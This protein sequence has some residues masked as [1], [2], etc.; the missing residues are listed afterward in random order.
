MPTPHLVS[1]PLECG[2]VRLRDWQLSDLDAY[3]HWMHPK[4]DWHKLD[5]PY[6]PKPAPDEIPRFVISK[7]TEIERDTWPM[8][9][10]QL[11]IADR[12]SDA[13][14]GMVSWYWIGE[15]TNWLAQG[16]VIY[17]PTYW[18]R[19]IGTVAFGLWGQYL[20]DAMPHIVRL[21]LRTWS[22][23]LGMQ[24]LARRL[25]YAEEARFRMARIV[26]GDYYDGLGFGI[27]RGEWFALYPHSFAAHYN[28][29]RNG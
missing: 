26:D 18:R 23:N 20:F 4:H 16:I 15:E 2:P 10:E 3:A 27:L 1:L 5:G 11:V 13:L 7:R 25:G 28:A 12:E 6:Y 14:L 17:D 29:P 22:G 19:G 21:D 9:R 24:S 8:P